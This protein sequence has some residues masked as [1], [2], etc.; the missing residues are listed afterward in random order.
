M[1]YMLGLFV[2]F[3]IGILVNLCTP[4]V[5]KRLATRSPSRTERRIKILKKERQLIEDYH[6]GTNGGLPRQKYLTG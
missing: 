6:T 4:W 5:Q 2:S 3:I 1:T